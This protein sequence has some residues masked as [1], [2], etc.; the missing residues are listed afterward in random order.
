[1]PAKLGGVFN[2]KAGPAPGAN[3]GRAGQVKGAWGALSDATKEMLTSVLPV[4]G[5]GGGCEA[6]AA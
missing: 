5:C 4:G 6:T 3:V 1:M 2:A